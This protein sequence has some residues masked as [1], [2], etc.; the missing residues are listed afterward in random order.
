[1][2]RIFL[3]LSVIFF[4]YFGADEGN[5]FQKS[6]ECKSENGRK[7]YCPSYNSLRDSQSLLCIQKEGEEFCKVVSRWTCIAVA[8]I[9]SVN[10]S[11]T[12][13]SKR[14][15]R[16]E[17]RARFLLDVISSIEKF[18]SIIE[19][20]HGHSDQPLP[21]LLNGDAESEDVRQYA[22][23]IFS[24]TFLQQTEI[25]CS[26]GKTKTLQGDIENLGKGD[27][28]K[29][30]DRSQAIKLSEA[31]FQTAVCRT[32]SLASPSYSLSGL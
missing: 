21:L 2:F 9:N 8:G 25:Q 26:L 14:D 22:Y 28:L 15:P 12:E 29:R 20:P 1:M 13:A 4:G 24:S 16:T 19:T 11:I 5:A 30:L 23:S 7:L 18:Y 31:C 17:L 10:C 6:L 27:F 32:D 3:V